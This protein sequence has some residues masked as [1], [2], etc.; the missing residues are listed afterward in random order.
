MLR[1][2]F[3]ALCIVV[4]VVGADL[5]V[6]PYASAA[7]RVDVLR[8]V[9]AL[10]PHISGLFEEP[11]AF[12]QAANGYYFVFDRR[13]HAIYMI[14]PE[15]ANARKVVDVGQEEGR[16]IQPSGFD[17]TPEGSFVV[18]DVPR[19]QERIQ[20]FGPGA[21]RTG[22]FFIAGR[23]MPQVI[24]GNY[25]LTGISSLQFNSGFAIHSSAAPPVRSFAR[26]PA[27]WTSSR[28]RLPDNW[29][30]RGE[31]C[32]RLDAISFA[33]HRWRIATATGAAG[34]MQLSS[35]LKKLATLSN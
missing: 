30:S 21:L 16:I 23:S 14:D 6:G 29:V 25:A 28:S 15:R 18:A 20:I 12:Q 9:G 26:P 11:V 17:T 19:G 10:P 34:S 5:K 7:V 13:A 1:T 27:G 31:W 32:C 2:K 33:K 35:P 24:I 4:I 22:G 3:A 8:S